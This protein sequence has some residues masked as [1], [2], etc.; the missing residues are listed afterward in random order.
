VRKGSSRRYRRL[1]VAPEAE[2]GVRGRGGKEARGQARAVALKI[3]IRGGDSSSKT[4][5]L[6]DGA[7]FIFH[8]TNGRCSAMF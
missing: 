7:R 5:E 4:H 2:E 1:R 6:N 8:P 3:L